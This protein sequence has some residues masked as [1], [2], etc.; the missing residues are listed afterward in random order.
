MIKGIVITPLNIIDTLGGEVMHAMKKS[1]AGFSG[2]GEAYFSHIDYGAIK[3]W[4]R[5]KKMTLNLVV[6][7]GKIRF[8][9]YDDRYGS[10]YQMQDVIISTATYCRLTVPPMV[11]MGFQGLA[12]T[13]SLLL[14]IANIEHDSS[15]VSRKH[16]N[17]IDFK[18][19]CIN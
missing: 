11:W 13:G 10:N 4:K 6:P 5:H 8:V 18:W 12:E 1:D 14:N 19:D 17:E 3:A 15:E 9:L 7:S 16:V 2:F